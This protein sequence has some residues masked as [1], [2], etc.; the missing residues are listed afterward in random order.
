MYRAGQA[1]VDFFFGSGAG[2]GVHP[3]PNVMSLCYESKSGHCFGERYSKPT[4]EHL[5]GHQTSAGSSKKHWQVRSQFIHCS[6]LR[7]PLIMRNKH[8]NP[9]H[10]IL[11]QLLIFISVRL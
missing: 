4:N 6:N 2:Q 1:G 8:N 9:L 3:S 5:H 10:K 11:L 7:E